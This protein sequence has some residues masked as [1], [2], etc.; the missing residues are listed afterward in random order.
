MEARQAATSA[1]D[2]IVAMARGRE[3]EALK[4]RKAASPAILWSKWKNP[5]IQIV[6]IDLADQ[7]RENL[8]SPRPS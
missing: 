1:E 6:V 5:F 3:I 2:R 8:I 4:W 7:N